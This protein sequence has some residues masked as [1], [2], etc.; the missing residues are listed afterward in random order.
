MRA[1]E[2]IVEIYRQKNELTG[3]GTVPTKVIMTKEQY[4]TLKRY[5][6]RLGELP[7][8]AMDYITEDSLFG[9]PIFLDNVD[10]CIVR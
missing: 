3:K 2:I 6:A 8:N 5:K 10:Q 4:D 1:E 7:D 9:L